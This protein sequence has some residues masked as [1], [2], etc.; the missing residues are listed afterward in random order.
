MRPPKEVGGVLW[1]DELKRRIASFV[2]TGFSLVTQQYDRH[3]LASMRTLVGSERAACL[4]C[5][6][7]L[8]RHDRIASITRDS[9]SS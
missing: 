2:A 1:V 4:L 7:Y 9:K 3:I 8:S 6:A 5:C